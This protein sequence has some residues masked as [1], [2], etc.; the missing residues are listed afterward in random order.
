MVLKYQIF[1]LGIKSSVE[2][3]L[4]NRSTSSKDLQQPSNDKSINSDKDSEKHVS[5]DIAKL[6]TDDSA[7][8]NQQIISDDSSEFLKKDVEPT[9]SLQKNGQYHNIPLSS[10][11]NA[12]IDF[13]HPLR[14]TLSNEESLQPNQELNVHESQYL[15]TQVVTRV[16]S[17]AAAAAATSA[18]IAVF[19]TQRALLSE[20]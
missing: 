12:T 20:V 14:L 18:V 16:A 7:V 2:D 9:T 5:E 6:Q 15:H 17:E 4:S 8:S 10:Q 13:R 19:E 1:F 3:I 11:N